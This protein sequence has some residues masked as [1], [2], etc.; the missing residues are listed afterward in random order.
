MKVLKPQRLGLLQRVV[1]HERRC[2]L[3]VSVLVYV[4]L[5]QP[6]K[7]LPEASLW[8]EL[9]A[10][11]PGGVL[12]EGLPKP[13]GEVLVTG[14]AFAPDSRPARAIMV[15]LGFGSIEK[16]LAV[17]GDRYWRNGSPTEPSTFV[18][19]PIDYAHAFGGEGYARN[20]VGKGIAAC[21]T[22]HGAVVPLPNVEDPKHL[23]ASRS[24]RPDPAGFAPY[25]LQWPQ[26]FD[27]VGKRYD[28]KWLETRFPGPAEDFDARF[29]NTA[30]LDQQAAD[31][32]SGNECFVLEGMHPR[33]QR[34][35]GG[36]ERL[37]VKVLATQRAADGDHWREI[38]T[39]LDTV[40]FFPHLERALRCR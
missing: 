4:P 28:R 27:N 22:E 26:R 12:D 20:P 2:T 15:R 25:P 32:F 33:A 17:V 40:H 39:R 16:T 1:E 3:V 35:E 19:M 11:L 13:C 30:P 7:L 9:A 18:E 29:Y 37:V 14:R 10:E 34:L 23:V 8:R 6:R 38:G 24:D 21:E 5:D 31:F 36:L